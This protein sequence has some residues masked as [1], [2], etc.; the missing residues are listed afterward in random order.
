MAGGFCELLVDVEVG[1][2]RHLSS[3]NAGLRAV[4]GV[5]QVE[6]ARG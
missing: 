3:V 6:R 2:L 1:D 4:S 5:H